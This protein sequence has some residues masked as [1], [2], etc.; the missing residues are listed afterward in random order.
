MQKQR[1]FRWLAVS[2]LAIGFV[3]FLLPARLAADTIASSTDGL[4]PNYDG[5]FG[6]VVTTPTLPNVAHEWFNVTFNWIAPDSSAAAFGTLFVLTQEYLGTPAALSSSTAGFV[7]AS[8]GIS[9]GMYDFASNV[10]LFPNTTYWFYSNADIPDG[11]IIGLGS[12]GD[13][14][15]ATSANTNFDLFSGIGAPDFSL[16]GTVPE[17]ATI[18]LVG[19]G[20]AAL[21]AFKRKRSLLN[22]T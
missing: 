11:A 17:P 5:Y 3:A 14:Y 13:T 22:K 9:G 6:A 10:K 7:A 16:K 8:T 1:L 21:A 4:V 18:S 20:I 12:S 19:L 2:C 15:Y